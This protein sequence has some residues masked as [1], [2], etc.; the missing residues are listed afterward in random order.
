MDSWGSAVGRPQLVGSGLANF[1][2]EP[3]HQFPFPPCPHEIPFPHALSHCF[4]VLE[5]DFA[6]NFFLK[7]KTKGTQGT[8]LELSIEQGGCLEWQGSWVGGAP[9]INR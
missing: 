5:V 2:G 8:D 7:V 3:P 6:F 1:A 4:F 9:V